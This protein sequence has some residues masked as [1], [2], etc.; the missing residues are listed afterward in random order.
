MLGLEDRI[1]LVTGAARGVGETIARR[2]A[3]AGARVVVADRLEE[4]G[5]KVALGLG[6]N[7]SFV[8]LDVTVETDWAR[9]IADTLERH[10]RIDVLVNNAAILHMG[11]LENTPPDVFRRVLEV[12]TVG[13]YLGTRAVLAAMRSQGKGSIV[14]IA[15]IDGLLGMNGVTAYATSKFGLRGFAKSCALELGRSGIRVNS[16]CP[17][18]GNPQMYGPWLPKMASM[19]ETLRHY[20][21]NRGIPGTVSFDAIAGAVLY[22]A[23]DLSE[24]VTGIDLPVDGGATAGKYLDGF[25]SL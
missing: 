24:H 10:G 9:A 13:P 15:S 8:P 21:E 16:V 2:L 7:A 14:H 1:A 22:L 25:S 11:S 17:A 6:P 20:G 3:E 18:G 23:S 5:R 4:E 19:T 12:N